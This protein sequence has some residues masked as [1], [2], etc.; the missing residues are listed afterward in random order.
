MMKSVL[1]KYC[2]DNVSRWDL[3]LDTVQL[4]LNERITERSNSAPFTLMFGRR[5]RPFRDL[6]EV[7]PSTQATQQSL[8]ERVQLLQS[9]VWPSSLLAVG[10]R[11]NQ[12]KRRFDSDMR[13]ITFK[14]GDRVMTRDPTKSDKMQARYEGPFLVVRRTRGGSYKLKDLTGEELTRNYA[15]SQLKRASDEPDG[16]ADNEDEHW[17][18]DFI[19]D[20]RDKQGIDEYLVRWSG[21]GPSYDSWVPSD[22]IDDRRSIRVYHRRRALAEYDGKPF[23]EAI[24]EAALKRLERAA[25]SRR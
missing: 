15:P 25:R 8:E 10:E 23:E 11:T 16:K 17:D 20:H 19:R 22:E 4:A 3:Y 21:Y 24:S 1:R 6:A 18:F 7:Q 13:Q 9:L 12:R 5:N 14:A 2:A